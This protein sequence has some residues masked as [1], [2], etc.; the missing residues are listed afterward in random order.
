MSISENLQ[1]I[2]SKI[3]AACQ[4][5][6]RERDEVQLIAVSKT[7]PLDLIQDAV[8]A[9]QLHFGENRVQ[10]LV[11]KQ[12]QLGDE[13]QWHLIGHL[14]KNKIRKALPLTDLLHTLD[15]IELARQVSRIAGEEGIT[16][17]ALVQVNISEDEAKY[18]FSAEAAQAAL[19]ELLELPHIEIR[20]LM[21]IPKFDPDPEATRIHFAALRELRD[22]L[23]VDQL[24]EL[25][26]GMSHDFGVAI[27]EGAT[28]VRV[29]S[30]I[31][32]A[33]G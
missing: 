18:G 1:S 29:G 33:R 6:G 7:K 17:R 22:S 19:D 25:S 21:T 28:L 24:A 11:D 12:P 13:A 31:F 10:E 30:A 5:S 23:G 20:G 27:E 16:C 3:V 15:S 26:M 14:Q 2:E 9:G 32:G 4:R 8:S